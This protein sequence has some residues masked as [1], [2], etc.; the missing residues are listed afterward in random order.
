MSLIQVLLLIT[1]K[2]TKN[3]FIFDC[4]VFFVVKISQYAT[5]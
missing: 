5:Y 2:N 4:F 1:T 3:F